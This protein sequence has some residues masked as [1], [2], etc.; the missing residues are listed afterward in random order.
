MNDKLSI[1]TNNFIN[2]PK[3]FKHLK[4]IKCLF[5]DKDKFIVSK[6]LPLVKIVFM[7]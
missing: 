3:S 5:L 2:F 6:S 4:N 1:T 7:P